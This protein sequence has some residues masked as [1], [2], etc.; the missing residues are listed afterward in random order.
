[1]VKAADLLGEAR[2]GAKMLIDAAHTIEERGKA[3]GHPRVNYENTARFFQAVLARKLLPGAEITPG[4]AA[5]MMVCVKLARLMTT[6][7]H[8]DSIL[9]IA[10]YS[11]CL[12]EIE[13][14]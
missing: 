11:A 10:G 12:L 2:A 9:D 3:Y 14:E 13:C 1:M 7:N 6:P 5:K 4:D 8:A